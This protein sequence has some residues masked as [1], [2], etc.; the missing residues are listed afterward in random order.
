MTRAT[1]DE[2][3]NH[4]RIGSCACTVRPQPKQF[5]QRESAEAKKP[6]AQKITSGWATKLFPC[7]A[8]YGKHAFTPI[9]MHQSLL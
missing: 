1:V 8:I 2:K 4:G 3:Q 9:S 6:R 5:G 7:V